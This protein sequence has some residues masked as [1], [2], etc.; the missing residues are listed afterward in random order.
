MLSAVERSFSRLKLFRLKD[1]KVKGFTSTAI[2][3]LLAL[4]T[5]P[6]TWLS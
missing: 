1:L 4:V 5:M 3:I 2:H 6:Q